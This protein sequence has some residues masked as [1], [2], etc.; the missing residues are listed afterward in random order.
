MRQQRLPELPV[1]QHK[2]AA[3]DN[4][5]A[6]MASSSGPSRICPPSCQRRAISGDSKGKGAGKIQKQEAG[7]IL[8]GD[9]LKLVCADEIPSLEELKL[10]VQ[11]TFSITEKFSLHYEDKDFNQFFTLTTLNKSKTKTLSMWSFPSLR[12]PSDSW[13]SSL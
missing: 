10:L 4:N 7:N 2:R 9:I 3:G 1:N 8:E 12:L 13:K 11:T 6:R 5:A